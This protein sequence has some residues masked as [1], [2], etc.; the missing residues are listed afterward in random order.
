[1]LT[2][3]IARILT[4][5]RPLDRNKYFCISM[6]GENY[7]DNI[8]SLSDYITSVDKKA[9][10]IWAFTKKFRN[11]LKCDY[12]HVEIYSIRYY[13][14]ILS[15]KFILSNSRLNSRML[16]KRKGQ[17]YL[18]TWHGTALKRIGSDVTPRRMKTWLMRQLKPNTFKFDVKSTDIM[19]S[20]SKFMTDIFRKKFGFAGPI[21]ETGTPRN[22]IF[23]SSYSKVNEKVRHRLKIE[24]NEYVVL[25][26]PT[27]RTGG[28]LTYYD[29]DIE[30]ILRSWEP[31]KDKNCR[32]L[33]R[34]HPLILNQTEAL[35]H[36]LKFSYTDVSYYPDI[37][38]LLCAADLLVTDYSS[39]MFDFMYTHKPIMMYVPDRLTYNRGFYFH[40]DELP[41][42]LF[43]N[44]KEI[45][46]K[47]REFDKGQY[48][49]KLEQFMKKIGSMEKGNA[50]EQIYEILQ[51]HQQYLTDS[52]QQ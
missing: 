32:C 4:C 21:L 45:P 50:A 2:Y 51:N 13:R 5:L 46:A 24:E 49:I 11:S 27:F 40:L 36:V 39:C 23:F 10:V 31:A 15:S 30:G 19:V 12:E 33:V 25:Y 1:M 52:K 37:Q 42:I 35:K 29:V 14:H 3:P 34:L 16:H 38:E 18:Q 41:F 6:I 48:N 28:D 26:A 7:G 43:N 20:G 44:N 47:I 22:D 8:K 9:T 17:V